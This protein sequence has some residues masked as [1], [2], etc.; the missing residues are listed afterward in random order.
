M[1]YV[2]KTTSGTERTRNHVWLLGCRLQI[3]TMLETHQANSCIG[4][5]VVVE[6]LCLHGISQGHDIPLTASKPYFRST[7][8]RIACKVARK[9]SP[10]VTRKHS[11]LHS[12]RHRGQRESA[13]CLDG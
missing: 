2:V 5:P 1:Y 4:T 12:F 3:L 9:H 10:K 11:T 6:S 8:A 13:I 7:G